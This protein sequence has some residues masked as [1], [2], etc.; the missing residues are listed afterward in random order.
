MERIV[1]FPPYQELYFPL[2]FSQPVLVE[3]IG[4]PSLQK[5]RPSWIRS[6]AARRLGATALDIRTRNSGLKDI[7]VLL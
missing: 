6:L 7:Q 1:Y 2:S 3:E 4:T 5:N